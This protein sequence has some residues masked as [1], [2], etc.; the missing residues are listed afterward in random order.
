[1]NFGYPK[2]ALSCTLSQ[3]VHP[4][5]KIS[6]F[7][8]LVPCLC[9]Y[10]CYPRGGGRLEILIASVVLG[11]QFLT[12][13]GCPWGITYSKCMAFLVNFDKTCPED[14]FCQNLNLYNF[15]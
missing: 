12:Q 3:N 9:T 1:M 7:T 11:M 13:N 2:S 6:F 5:H 8:F 4:N 14:M 15:L 10:Q